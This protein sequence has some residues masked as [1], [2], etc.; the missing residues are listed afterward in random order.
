MLIIINNM[1]D[2]SKQYILMFLRTHWG[3]H[4]CFLPGQ[5]LKSSGWSNIY[6]SSQTPPE[7]LAKKSVRIFSM[8]DIA[9]FVFFF[10][11][12]PCMPSTSFPVPPFL[13]HGSGVHRDPWIL[14]IILF[15]IINATSMGQRTKYILV[16]IDKIQVHILH[17]RLSRRG[18]WGTPLLLLCHDIQ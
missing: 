12:T 8:C 9:D 17:R 15:V 16:L 13:S 4:C 3:F 2:F 10:T 1:W 6:N 7:W 14:M 11:D 5:L 18:D